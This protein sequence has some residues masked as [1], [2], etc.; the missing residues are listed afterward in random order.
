MSDFPDTVFVMWSKLL[1]THFRNAS[2]IQPPDDFKENFET[3]VTLV[4]DFLDT[5]DEDHIQM[6]FQKA[7][8]NGLVDTKIGIYSIWHDISVYER[9]LDDEETLFLGHMYVMS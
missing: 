9:G 8:L 3:Q 6:E 5:F 1:T 4:R 7:L 2:F